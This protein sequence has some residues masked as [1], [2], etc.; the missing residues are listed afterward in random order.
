[1]IEIIKIII[2]LQVPLVFILVIVFYQAHKVLRKKELLYISVAWIVNLL[3]LVI[4]IIV[5]K[6]KQFDFDNIDQII[7]TS[8]SAINTYILLAM[9]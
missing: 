3:Y 2:P 6:E 8:L 1:M 5:N 7:T 4:N 9:I